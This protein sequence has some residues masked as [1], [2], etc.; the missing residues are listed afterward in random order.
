MVQ[1]EVQM[2]RSTAHTRTAKPKPASPITLRLHTLL[3]TVRSIA[4]V[5]DEL[6]TLLHEA[7]RTGSLTPEAFAELQTLLGKLPTHEYTEDL[8]AVRSSLS[9]PAPARRPAAKKRSSRKPAKT[10]ATAKPK[11][12]KAKS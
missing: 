12:R 10:K 3:H 6:C 2:P 5:E 7:E 8:E 1:G 4:Q 11:A 9:I